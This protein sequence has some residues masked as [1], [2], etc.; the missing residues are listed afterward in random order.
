MVRR[1]AQHEFARQGDRLGRCQIVGDDDDGRRDRRK[2]HLL[3]SEQDAQHP[4]F[5]VLDVADAFAQIGVV[6]LPEARAEALDD[7][8][9]GRLDVHALLADDILDLRND[10]R[11]FQYDQMVGEHVGGR[12]ALQPRR[13]RLDLPPRLLHRRGEAGQLGGHVGSG[14]LA[15]DHGQFAAVRGV[16]KHRTGGEPA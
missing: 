13:Q 9:D 15:L 14:Y 1:N 2:H 4:P 8:A 5:D 3:A 16:Q 6:H 7:A 10:E 11:V 12:L